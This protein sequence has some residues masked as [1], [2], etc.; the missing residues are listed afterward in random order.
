MLQSINRLSNLPGRVFQIGLLLARPDDAVRMC[1]HNTGVGGM[2][3]ILEALGGSRSWLI[4]PLKRDSVT[5]LAHVA[6][7]AFDLTP[8]GIRD[9]IGV[10]LIPRPSPD[11]DRFAGWRHMLEAL[12]RDGL[13]H[14]T[15]RDDL[16][17]FCGE[18]EEIDCP[19]LWPTNLSGFASLPA[20]PVPVLN[21][22][23]HHVKLSLGV[24]PLRAKIYFG[25]VQSWRW[26][27]PT[28]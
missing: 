13:C 7:L 11:R 20:G 16:V 1:I 24:A 28:Q 21:R 25:F 23:L 19:D 6:F 10:E 17:S 2:A 4:P 9:R 26:R 12:H 15:E 3:E 5:G 8:N 14:A 18:T 27:K 22:R